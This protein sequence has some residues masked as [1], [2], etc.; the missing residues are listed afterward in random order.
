[1]GHSRNTS[2]RVTLQH[3]AVSPSSI[4]LFF[5]FHQPPTREA[6][7]GELLVSLFLLPLSYL[8]CCG[9]GLHFLLLIPPSSLHSA[10]GEGGK[11]CSQ[12]MEEEVV[13]KRW[14]AVA[15]Y[16]PV[17][18]FSLKMD[19]QR[20]CCCLIAIARDEHEPLVQWFILVH[21]P[22]QEVSSGLTPHL[23][24]QVPTLKPCPGFPALPPASKWVPPGEGIVLNCQTLVA[25]VN[26]L[27]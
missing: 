22:S 15:P 9:G 20:N 10:T 26:K 12:S 24:H 14:K 11:S 5:F 7:D 16:C 3:A 1:M 19:F 13:C 17:L 23:L 4:S 21:L 25:P 27:G 2:T 8:H 18:G 6:E